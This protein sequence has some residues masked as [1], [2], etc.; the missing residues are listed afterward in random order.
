MRHSLL[1]LICLFFLSTTLKAFTFKDSVLENYIKKERYIDAIRISTKQLNNTADLSSNTTSYYIYQTMYSLHQLRLN[2]QLEQ[3]WLLVQNNAKLLDDYYVEKMY[4]VQLRFL[5]ESAKTTGLEQKL[6]YS[7]AQNKYA[8][9]ANDNRITLGSFYLS[10]NKVENAEKLYYKVYND[11]ISDDIQKGKACNGIGICFFYNG[12]FDS[13]S[14]YYHKAIAL[15]SKILSNKH[16]NVAQEKFNLS[17]ITNKYGAYEE[18]E[19]LLLEALSIY[20]E[21]FGEDHPRTAEVYGTL[22]G[23]YIVKDNTGK[24]LY[25]ILKERYALQKLYGNNYPDLAYSYLNAGK[26]YISRNEYKLAEQEFKT[27]IKILS[28]T[29]RIGNNTYVLLTIKLSEILMA[30]KE[31]TAAKQLLETLIKSAKVDEEYK[32]D[33]LLQLGYTELALQQLENATKHI[34]DANEIYIKYYGKKNVFS[35]ETNIALSDCFIQKGNF[36]KAKEFATIAKENTLENNIVIYP[37]DHWICRLQEIKCIKGAL[38]KSAYTQQQIVEY[39]NDIK[40]ILLEATTIKNSYYTN[41]SQMI[42][43]EKMT[44]LNSIGIYFLTHFYK[45]ADIYFIDNLLFFAENNKANLLKS[46][47]LADA[48]NGI[49]PLEEQQKAAA[50]TERLNYL[51]TLDDEQKK[52]T[53][54]INDSLIFYQEKNEQLIKYIEK[55]YPK[56]YQLKYAKIVLTAK[57]I[58]DKLSDNYTFLEYCND[59]EQYY[60]IAISKNNITYKVCGNKPYI[61]T[62]INKHKQTIQARNVTDSTGEKLTELLLPKETMENILISADENIQQVVFD[63]LP[64]PTTKKY[65]VYKHP[66]QYVFS[67]NTYFTKRTT[68][69]NNNIVAFFPDFKHTEFDELN[70]TKE[71]NSL[72]S[73]SNYNVYYKNTALK[74]TFVQV[75]KNAGVIHVASHL[76]T[77]TLSPL[78]SYIVFQPNNDYKLTINE[79]W[80]LTTNAQLITLAACQ[81]NF[82]KQQYGEGM[83]NFAWA[84]NY[85]GAQNILSTQWDAADKTTS[86][87]ISNFYTNLYNGKPKLKALQLAKI[88]YLNNT[89]AIGSQP[90]YWANFYFFGNDSS[91]QISPH[92]FIKHWYVPILLF[93][94]ITISILILRR[95]YFKKRYEHL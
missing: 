4:G 8:D 47:L 22:G 87:I 66:I 56:I 28:E 16:T 92:F 42:Y 59:G 25:Y 23:L 45:K 71:H 40:D 13:A 62:Q 17:L 48:T 27:G 85:A 29:E 75:I 55:K 21:V 12:N 35:I 88:N 53:Y 20:R 7:I 65:I 46:K 30:R 24:A 34:T 86:A 54:N 89:D 57:Q 70:H 72:K 91:L 84:F 83:Q 15:Y 60:C 1:L 26:V 77:D 9:I 37:Y 41:G 52:L 49:L 76:I 58:Q 69:D 39:I 95:I 63:A 64:D 10:N 18:T 38:K 43:N 33:I 32:A 44:A 6:L 81:S 68:D 51:I 50:I 11:V 82:G 67:A 3:I 19:K 61:N 73:F 31:Y 2:K 93:L 80:K 79:I 14:Y 36:I 74:N 5:K 94:I 90:F 78:K